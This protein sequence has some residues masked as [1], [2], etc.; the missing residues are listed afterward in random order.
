MYLPTW[1]APD[2]TPYRPSN[3]FEGQC[4]AERMC[5]QCQRFEGC[6]IMVRAM[7]FEVGHA[8]YPSEW[9]WQNQ[10]P[11][12]TAFVSV[13]PTETPPEMQHFENR[14]LTRR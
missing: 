3:G 13:K 1:S 7:A 5:H 12:C 6:R 9:C 11:V 14:F 8:D 2:G 10:K 4:F